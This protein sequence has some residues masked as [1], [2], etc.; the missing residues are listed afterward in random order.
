MSTHGE[1]NDFSEEVGVEIRSTVR[2]DVSRATEMDWDGLIG[3][4]CGW[5]CR[6]YMVG[7][8]ACWLAL[9]VSWLAGWLS[10]SGW[11]ALALAGWAGCK[12]IKT[13][14]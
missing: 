2:V 13:S 4:L 3:C 6:L 8:L 12:Q 14:G 10:G 7:W 5:A 1:S 9:W 11:A